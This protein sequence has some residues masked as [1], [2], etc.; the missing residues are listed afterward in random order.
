MKLYIFRNKN[1]YVVKETTTQSI[2][3][4]IATIGAMA[5]IFGCGIAY[6]LLLNGGWLVD[7]FVVVL[8]FAWFYNRAED[9]KQNVT[10]EELKKMI[11]ELIEE[12]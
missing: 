7:L 12:E 4:D 5:F 6:R 2:L 9:K 8:V 11:D 3:S 10:K 1:L